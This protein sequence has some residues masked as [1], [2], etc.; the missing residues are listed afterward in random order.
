M[1]RLGGWNWGKFEGS[2]KRNYKWRVIFVLGRGWAV[3]VEGVLTIWNAG[4]KHG[5]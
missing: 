1:R 3:F 5:P 2:T 4:Y